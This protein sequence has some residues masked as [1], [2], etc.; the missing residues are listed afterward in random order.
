MPSSLLDNPH[1][2]SIS[3]SLFSE[4]I[5]KQTGQHG[6]ITLA[7]RN[8]PTSASVRNRLPRVVGLLFVKVKG[9][10]FK[11][12]RN[13]SITPGSKSTSCPISI[14]SYA[15][16]FVDDSDGV[17]E[18][19]RGGYVLSLQ[20]P[21]LSRLAT[22]N[23]V[24]VWICFRAGRTMTYRDYLTVFYTVGTGAVNNLC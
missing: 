22:R 21:L 24:S 16:L 13:L 1:R 17:E 14:H 7:S 10:F 20:T 8:V 6:T 4:T 2:S 5:A 9:I 19:S 18:T 11:Y 12:W 15:R 23:A 3:K